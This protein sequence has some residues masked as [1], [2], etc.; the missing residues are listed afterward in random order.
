MLHGVPGDTL[1]GLVKENDRL[2]ATI[3]ALKV[4]I[5]GRSRITENL[6][7]QYENALLQNEGLQKIAHAAEAYCRASTQD[8]GVAL[9]NAVVKYYDFTEKR[10][11]EFRTH[12]HPCGCETIAERCPLHTR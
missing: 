6:Q 1:A 8:N 2:R 7:H 11:D 4:E 5:G 9:R 10:K 12:K 3:E